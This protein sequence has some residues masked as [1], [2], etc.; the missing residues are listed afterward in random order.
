MGTN[1]HG[2]FITAGPSTPKLFVISTSAASLLLRTLDVSLLSSSQ[3][4]QCRYEPSLVREVVRK[5]T[6]HSSTLFR[7]PLPCFVI[8]GFTL[9]DRIADTSASARLGRTSRSFANARPRSVCRSSHPRAQPLADRTSSTLADGNAR[10]A[11]PARTRC[12][13]ARGGGTR[14]HK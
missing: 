1:P 13:S 10:L 9:G 7:D 11:S 8:A 5:R 4:F 3:S 12:T 6:T 14:R 2:S